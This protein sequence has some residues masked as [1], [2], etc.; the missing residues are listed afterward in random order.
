MKNI[1]KIIFSLILITGVFSCKDYIDEAFRNPNNPTVVTPGDAL[2]SMFSNLARGIQF[3][4]RFLGRYVQYWATTTAGGSWDRHGYDI[5]SDNGGEKWRSHYFTLGQNTKNMIREGLAVNKPEYAGAGYA[6]F[7]LSW[8]QLT[9]YHGE[10]I[11]KQSFDPSRLVFNYDKQE[12]VYALALAQCDSALTFFNQVN[13]PSADFVTADNFFFKGDITKWK[14]FVNGTKAKILHRYSLKK[15]YK[16]DEVIKAVDA[17]LANNAD[18]AMVSFNNG[19]LSTDEANFYGARRNNLS[20]YRPTDFFIRL[21]DG[22]ILKNQADTLL[23]VRDPRLTYMF[24]PSTDGTFRGLALNLG[25]PTTTTAAR[26]TFNFYGTTL[27]SSPAAAADTISRTFF[28]AT[29]RFPIMT[30]A[31]L[32]FIKAE[33][34]FIKG[35]KAL[36]ASAWEAGIRSHFNMFDTQFNGYRKIS[37]SEINNYITAVTPKAGIG[38][39]DIMLQKFIAL[40]GHGYEE[41]WVD[42]RRYNYSQ[43]IYP[44][45]VISTFFPDNTS[46]FAHRVRPRYNS[47]YLWNVESLKTI[48]GLDL[49]YHT[50]PVWFSIKE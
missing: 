39:K 26:R 4:S 20:T 37:A 30:H 42:L 6:L 13:S 43:A 35:D 40:W 9:D 50:I 25:E 28:Q 27:A 23:A 15:N 32:Q 45:W 18:N 10:V 2:P 44:T 24:R 14:K 8:L 21:L 48:K 41:T 16:A 34:A 33:A 22:S 31:E 49:D 12:E 17:A 46:K 29:S 11:L 36:A 38:I 7:A 5:G 1:S 47:E 3:D 19:P